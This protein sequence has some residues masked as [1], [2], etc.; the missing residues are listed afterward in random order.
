MFRFFF[1]FRVAFDY[2]FSCYAIWLEWHSGRKIEGGKD[3]PNWDVYKES[4]VDGW[5]E[6]FSKRV[7]TIEADFENFKQDVHLK[8]KQLVLGAGYA[9]LGVHPNRRH[10]MRP[11]TIYPYS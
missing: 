1:L 10:L 9:G 7:K 2:R 4:F 11:L 6:E 8:I 5:K 3:G